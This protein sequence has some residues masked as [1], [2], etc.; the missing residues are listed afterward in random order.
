MLKKTRGEILAPLDQRFEKR[1]AQLELNG[2]TLAKSY[3][4]LLIRQ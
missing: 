4:D 2:R 3:A 1:V